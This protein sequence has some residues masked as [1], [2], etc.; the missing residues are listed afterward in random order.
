MTEP[1]LI[2]ILEQK[3]PEE[4]Q[5]MLDGIMLKAYG[6]LMTEAEVVDL[7]GY[8]TRGCL[9][10]DRKWKGVDIDFFNL[11]HR[12]GKFAFYYDVAAWLASYWVNT[13]G[14]GTDDE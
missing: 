5:Q 13:L 9:H 14:G 3:S 1:K 11:E 7:L 8:E 12:K 10:Y 2:K 6:P 4:F